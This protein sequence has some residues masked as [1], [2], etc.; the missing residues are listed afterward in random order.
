MK[1]KKGFWGFG[2]ALRMTSGIPY[3]RRLKSIQIAFVIQ[4]L[5]FSQKTFVKFTT[6]FAKLYGATLT[7]FPILK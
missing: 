2:D 3:D 6:C 5:H 1:K 4:I 7:P